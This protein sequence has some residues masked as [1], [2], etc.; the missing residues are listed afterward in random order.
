MRIVHDQGEK[1][2]Y[3]EDARIEMMGVPI[4]YLP[5]SHNVPDSDIEE[6]KQRSRFEDTITR[7][8]RRAVRIRCRLPDCRC[9]AVDQ[10]I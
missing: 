7:G 9:H 3:F 5:Y 1:M 2:M 8:N 4:A 10:L 6:R